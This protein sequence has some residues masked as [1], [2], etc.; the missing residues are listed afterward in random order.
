MWGGLRPAL[1]LPLYHELMS[2]LADSSA[3]P[4]LSSLDFIDF[5]FATRHS[6]PPRDIVTVH[7]IHSAR[8]ISNC[9]LPQRSEDADALLENTPGIAIGIK[10]ADCVPVLLADPVRRA[11]AAIHAGWRGTAAGIV[12]AAIR[13]MAAGF[14]TQPEDL[15]AAIGPSIGPC[16]YQVGP[17]VA[18]HFG[19]VA[20]DR[21]HLNLRYINARQL[22]AA[23]VL[24]TNISTTSDC[25]RCQPDDYHSFRR[26]HEIAGRM[27]S[28]IRIR[29]AG[30]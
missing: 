5:S 7:Q 6:V 14:G 28:W 13:S 21:V 18:S 29:A 15:H 24:P 25:T 19:V 27:I 9:G 4:S 22:E 10:T 20:T 12:L 23:G 3:Y 16:C 11:V 26:D 2:T 8:V 30:L 17:E 1:P